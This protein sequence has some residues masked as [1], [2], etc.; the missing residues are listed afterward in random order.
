[1]APRSGQKIKLFHIVDI[2]KEHSDENHPMNATE[3]CEKL[4]ALGVTAERKAIYDDIEQL[5]NYGFDIIKT[6]TP[7]NGFFLGER[8][9]ELPE[10]YLLCDAVRTARFI[11]AKKTRK[12]VTKLQRMMSVYN[13]ANNEFGIIMDTSLKTKNE[14]IFYT[15]DTVGN[16]IKRA[17][18]ITFKY[19]RRSLSN[20]RKIITNYKTMTVTPYAMIWQD[21]H[22]Y[23]ISNNEKYDNLMHLRIDRMRSV[24]MT[25]KPAR[26]ADEIPDFK[27]TGYDVGEYTKRLFSMHGGKMADVELVCGRGILE[28][29]ADRFGEDLFIRNVTDTTFTVSIKAALSSALVTYIINY[30]KD[31]TVKKPEELRQMVK[32]RAEEIG[33]MYE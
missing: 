19:G 18:K 28:Q 16:A 5:V 1:M 15:I 20:D 22:Y 4:A 26:K 21:D 13:R 33:K 6:R 14:D 32:L 24:E 31:I 27:E 9:F 3:I 10:I 17:K 23:L 25:Y 30:G 11:S 8:E 7:K 2:L 29:I 12:L